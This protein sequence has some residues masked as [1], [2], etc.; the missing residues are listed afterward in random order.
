M[1]SLAIITSFSIDSLSRRGIKKNGD[2]YSFSVPN[3]S[4]QDTYWPP[5]SSNWIEVAPEF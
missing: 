5:N 4:A 1:I 3:L 2:D